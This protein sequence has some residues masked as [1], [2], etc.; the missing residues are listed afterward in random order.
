MPVDLS[1]LNYLC[2]FP[3]RTI[4]VRFKDTQDLAFREQAGNLRPLL[5]RGMVKA[6]RNGRGYLKHLLLLVPAM[7]ARRAI[8]ESLI[9]PSHP[10]AI[11]KARPKGLDWPMRA[12]NAKSCGMRRAMCGVHEVMFFGPDS[13]QGAQ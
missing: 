13:R 8:R 7:V 3:K 6:A 9:P 11:T 12:D 4:D 2:D 10:H 5:R 1:T